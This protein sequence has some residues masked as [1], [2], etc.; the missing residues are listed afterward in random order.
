MGLRLKF[1]LVLGIAAVIIFLAASYLARIFFMEDA[2][3]EVIRQARIMMESAV[4]VRSYTVKEV[5]PLLA[6]Q[7]RRQFLPQTVPAYAASR[8]VGELQ[9]EYPDYSYK[10]AVFNPTNPAH[11]AQ[12]WEADI[13][14]WFASHRDEKE[15]IGERQ[16]QTGASL[17]LGL[18]IEIT[19][20][21]CL[22]CHGTVAD[23]PSTMLEQ[24]GTAGG[25]GWKL[26]EV[27]GVQLVTVPTSIPYQQAE[28]ALQ[29]FMITLGS[30][31]ATLLILLN[32]MLHFIVIRPVRRIAMQADA[33]SMGT[34]NVEEI[35]YR[36]SDEIAS[37]A[38]SVNRMHRSLINAME[39]LDSDDRE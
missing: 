31:I 11:R 8:Y 28:R 24:Y 2:K 34:L 4:A 5:K 20:P 16:A 32:L 15:F 25:F 9:K 27:I 6:V 36:G 37:M 30:V 19:D 12:D 29:G 13:I 33:V 3:A 23:A 1:N 38:R 22:A 26:G 18:P 7:S 14:N 10:E 21:K 35:S 17:Y 39:M